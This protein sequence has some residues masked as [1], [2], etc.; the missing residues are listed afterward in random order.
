M[1]DADEA[2][3]VQLGADRLRAEG[4]GRWHGDWQGVQESQDH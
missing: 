2:I 3:E 1:E 4:G